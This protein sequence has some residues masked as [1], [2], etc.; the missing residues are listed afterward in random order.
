MVK[1][2]ILGG[3]GSGKTTL[4]QAVSSLFHVPHYDLDQLGRKHGT[5]AAG[6]I[7]DTTAITQQPG[8]VTEGIYLLYIDLLLHAADYIVLLD[9]SWPTAARR[10][11][12]RHVVNS[13]RGTNQYP[14]LQ[15]LFNLLKYARTYYLN[16]RPDTSEIVRSYFAKYGTAGPP[17]AETVLKKLDTY[18]SALVIPPSAAFVRQYVEPYKEKV[19][20]VRNQ[21]DRARLLQLLASK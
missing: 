5:Q 11:I 16:K 10:I 6:Y 18:G 3:P 15:S 1:V 2:H 20:V 13:L 19:V 4:A 17:T 21:Q 9:V 14:G 7:E 8:W 12:W